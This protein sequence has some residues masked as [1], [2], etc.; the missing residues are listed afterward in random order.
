MVST[1]LLDISPRFPMG[2]ATMYKPKKYL[3]LFLL[4]IFI[5]SCTSVNL[6]NQTSKSNNKKTVSIKKTE[7]IH[8]K[9]D[10][11]KENIVANEQIKRIFSDSNLNKSAIPY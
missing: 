10:T 6:S 9:N 11:D 4:F 1:A 8:T 5:L 7:K 3:S 2:V